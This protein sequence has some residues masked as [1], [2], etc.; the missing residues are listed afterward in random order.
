MMRQH[1]NP[2]H[3][4]ST[5]YFGTLLVCMGYVLSL[6][7]VRTESIDFDQHIQPF[8]VRRCIACHGPDQQKGGL[9][10]DLKS[11]TMKGGKNG[12]VINVKQPDQSAILQRINSQDPDLRMPPEGAPPSLDE[13]LALRRWIQQ[14]AAWPA[15][16]SNES[17]LYRHWA[18]QNVISPTPPPPGENW[19]VQNPVD[20]FIQHRLEKQGLHLN[21]PAEQRQLIRRMTLDLTGL[22]A[23]WET[24]QSFE[25][26][27]SPSAID[28][29]IDRL[30]QS[31]HYGERWG[32]HWLDVA[33]FNESQGYERDKHRPN[34]WRYRDYVIRSFNQNK[35]YDQF[36]R[37]QIAGDLLEPVTQDGIIATGFLVAGPWDEVGVNQINRISRKQVREDELEEMIGT[38]GQTFLATTIHCARCHS[39]K[40][41]PIPLKDYYRI[42][43][44]LDGAH[45]GDRP[46]PTTEERANYARARRTIESELK[47]I[48]AKR[49]AEKKEKDATLNAAIKALEQELKELD[50]QLPKSYA[51]NPREPDVTQVLARGDVQQALEPVSAGGLSMLR[52]LDYDFGLQPNAKES[53]RRR[54]LA[55][56]VTDPAN[57]LL[58][59]V[60][61]NRIWHYHFGRGLVTTPN[62]FGQLGA[63]PS[64]PELLDWLAT[65]FIRSGWDVKHMHRLIM[66]SATYQ[67][68]SA[69]DEKGL[70]KDADN[71]WLW[72]FSPRRVE[73]EV[74]RD[75]MLMASGEINYDMEGPGYKSYT[76]KVNNSH[77][78]TWKDH[79]GATYN[80]RSVYR[81]HVQ[82]AND[83]LMDSLDCPRPSDLMPNRSITTTPLQ[84]LTLMNNSVVLRQAA[85]M[86]QDLEQQWPNNTQQ[87]IQSA[88]QRTMQRNPTAEELH[89][90][91]TLA[92]EHGLS[93]VC[94]VL[95]NSSEFL[96]MQ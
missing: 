36:V 21:P 75:A 83:P 61:A 93:Q 2:V 57:P 37:E 74:A 87:A 39:H 33:R 54:A 32:R 16:A 91:Q 42:K 44:A 67:Q 55:D 19:R 76:L 84:A 30:L 17:I 45:H 56:W 65:E 3:F 40:Y 59:R 53:S 20:L 11:T 24:I 6:A 68:S 60:M 73:G 62:D 78:Y 38:L 35:P 31:P 7:S 14:G 28:Q 15:D 47:A 94:W 13:R 63:R 96:Y 82:S 51:A 89:E 23:S 92:A 58:A 49:T 86:A 69:P 8:L 81:T 1:T 4:M 64:H 46:I 9:R 25:K 90:H 95:L 27:T 52:Q 29:V 34:A 12:P 22:P 43:A 18:Y 88:F 80:R 41:D 66:S 85:K 71:Q 26:T 5:S 70:K 79:Q 50:R 10:L 48:E 77:F 72:R